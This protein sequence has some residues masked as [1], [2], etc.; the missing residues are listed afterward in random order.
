MAKPSISMTDAMLDDIDTQPGNNR[1]EWV[2]EAVA[3]RLFIEATEDK[4][5]NL[6]DEWW[7]DAVEAYFDNSERDSDREP[8]S[9]EA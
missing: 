2:C 4:R 1:S 5:L 9:I 7:K 6:P 3:M 8:A